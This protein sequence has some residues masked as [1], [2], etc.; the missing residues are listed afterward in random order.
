MV[1]RMTANQDDPKGYSLNSTA[2]C[3]TLNEDGAVL[4]DIKRGICF[5]L[6]FVGAKIWDSLQKGYGRDSIITSLSEDF[7]EIPSKRIAED[8]DAFLA[9]LK[10]KGLLQ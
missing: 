10:S 4:L 1:T 2:I 6:S 5:S 8:V 3:T 7:S 9:D